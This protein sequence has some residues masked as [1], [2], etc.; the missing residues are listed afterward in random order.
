[1]DDVKEMEKIVPLITCEISLCQYL[2]ELVCGVDTLDLNLWIQ[3]HS[4]KQQL[5]GFWVRASLWDVG[6]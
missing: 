4:V 5:G 6:L 1:M 2:C 3:I